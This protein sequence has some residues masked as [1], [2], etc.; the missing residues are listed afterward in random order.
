MDNYY[1]YIYLDPRKSGEYKYG[2][3]EFEYKPF[4][5][6]K[7]KNKRYLTEY[8]RNPLF[9]NKI[10]KIK[11]LKQKPIIFKLYENLDEKTSFEIEEKLIKEIGRIDLGTG[12][13][14][15][16][17]DG[18]EGISGYKHTEETRKKIS[19]NHDDRKGEKHP[20]FG[21]HRFGKDA[22]N[23]GKNHSK[24]CKNKISESISGKNHYL[25]G[26]HHSIKTK[27]KIS[28]SLVGNIVS[29]ETRNKI[30]QTLKE[31]FKNSNIKTLKGEKHPRHKL[32]EQQVIQIKLLLKEGILTQQEIADM[33][34]VSRQTISLIKTGKIWSHI[35]LG[36]NNG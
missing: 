2:K 19:I 26:K 13:L 10:N 4:Y 29:K 12:P 23:F 34:G 6:G 5:I 8:G 32:T 9:K 25:Y 7:G 21:I 22:P 17:T 3:Y 31:K 20:M 28:E 1:V 27:N 33:F 15:N 30:S 18:G 14:V 24:E 16:M 11:K 35:K 36:E